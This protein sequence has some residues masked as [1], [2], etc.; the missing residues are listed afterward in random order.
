[1][2]SLGH[3]S[4]LRPFR[5]ERFLL[6]D[7]VTRR[8][9]ELTRT[10][11]DGGRDGSL[12]SAVD[13]TATPMGSRLLQEWL[14]A[15]PPER[16]A[17]EQRLDAVAELLEEPALRQQLRDSLAQAFDLQRLTARVSTGRATP[18]DLVH[19]ARTL[20]L[21]PRLKAKLSA[22]RAA[23]LNELESRL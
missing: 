17:I 18:R 5:Q 14:G 21:L 3:L 6:L 2:A 15:P 11:R 7:E 1:K 9:L 20:S 12:L 22:R 8:S 10:L 23:L 19:V 4:R 13:R 16:R